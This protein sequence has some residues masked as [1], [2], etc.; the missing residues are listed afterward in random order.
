MCGQI[1][2]NKMENEKPSLKW[3][4]DTLQAMEVPFIN[5]KIKIIDQ[6]SECVLKNKLFLDLELFLEIQW[7]IAVLW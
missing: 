6:L 2:Y 4:L 5:S 3:E 7:W 1:E